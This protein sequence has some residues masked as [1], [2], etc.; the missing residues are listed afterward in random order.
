M[1]AATKKINSA[2]GLLKVVAYMAKYG[3]QTIHF[4]G[5]QMDKLEQFILNNDINEETGPCALFL[6][7][8]E[9]AKGSHAQN[10]T[11]KKASL[12]QIMSRMKATMRP[13]YNGQ[14]FI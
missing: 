8:R 6:A 3:Q 12:E 1:L 14:T 13:P 11:S 4:Y 10:L 9:Y 7:E 5:D 2:V